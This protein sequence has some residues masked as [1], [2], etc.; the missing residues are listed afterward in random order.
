MAKKKSSGQN[1]SDRKLPQSPEAEVALLGSILFDPSVLA[2]VA[3]I[4]T[5]S[6]FFV[7]ANV[8]VAQVVFDLWTKT[9]K[10]VDV[11]TVYNELCARKQ[12]GIVGGEE[13]LFRLADARYQLAVLTRQDPRGERRI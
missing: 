6:D 1:I 8:A 12:D 4:V 3:D 9:D 10:P 11:V 7:P 2:E 5:P 13:G